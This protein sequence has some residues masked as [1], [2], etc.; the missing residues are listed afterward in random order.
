VEWDEVVTPGL[1]TS[2]YVLEDGWVSVPDAP[3]FGLSLDE[4]AFARAVAEGGWKVSPP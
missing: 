3:G 4:A 2:G 1:D